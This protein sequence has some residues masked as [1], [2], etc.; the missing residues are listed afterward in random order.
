MAI[1]TAPDYEAL[2]RGLAVD[3]QL[4]H[5]ER[6]PARPARTAP[7]ALDLPDLLAER[8]P[9]GGLWTHQAA[10]VD[11]ARSGRS[12]AV[13]TGTASG[14]S[15]CYQLPLAAAALESEPATALMIFPTKALAQDQ[16]RA[17]GAME[18]PDLVAVT[19][20]GDTAP[21]DRPFARRHA[22]V[23][24]TNPDMLHVGILPHHGRWAT[25]LMRLRYVVLDELHTLRGI[26]GSH[27]A[28]LLRRLRRLC[29]H[30]GSNPTFVFG[31]ATI[32]RP[33]ALAS[34]LCGMPVVE[35]DDDGSPRGERLFALWNPP[36]TDERSAA[37][38]SSNVE[39]A[40]VLAAL[41]SSGY[42]G[43]AF[44]RSRKGSELV[45]SYAKR[46]L[47]PELASM[48]R[49]YRGGYL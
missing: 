36:I 11:L 12:V 34:A 2:L 17:L 15:L 7:L 38:A 45:A 32:G 33:S 49:P 19:Y 9:P 6:I 21:A 13:A 8:L 39:T 42:R 35:V 20:D 18:V 43:I 31:S 22:D 29:A 3:G 41:V 1:E 47:P 24:L 27:V 40:E 44:T 10:A 23:I 30:Y 28:H 37:R 4:V 5:I 26:F 25:F 46:R 14:K 48:V 16:L